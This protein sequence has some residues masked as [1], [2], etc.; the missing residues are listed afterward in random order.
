M[1]GVTM[2][3]NGNGEW[4]LPDTPE[5]L[6]A[7]G[8]PTPDYDAVSFAV[9]NLGFIKLQIFGQSII[10]IELHPRAVELPALLAAQQQV[11]SSQVKLFRIKYFDGEWASEITSAAEQVIARLS[12]LCAPRARPVGADRF[13]V[14][15]QDFGRLFR[16]EDN[17]LRPLAVK[18]R[19]SFGQFDSSVISLAVANGLL[20]RLVIVGITPGKG[21]PQWRFIGDGHKWIGSNYHL[22]GLGEQV[23]NMPDKDYGQWAQEYF[24]STAATR[25]PRYDL[26]SGSIQ[27]QD[28]A[29]RPSVP[30]RYERLL[31]PWKTA[32]AEVFVTSCS[33]GIDD[34]IEPSFSPASRMAEKVA[35][36]A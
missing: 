23:Q 1:Q 25:Q 35:N 18:W 15:P 12:E 14:E 19:M 28:A 6:E 13:V 22:R 8:D 29:G 2:L 4:L 11:L 24:K 16:E 17:W 3:V 32:S 27:Y 31:L 10:E 36:S 34:V 7:L 9:K 21:E 26:V 5:F 20:S 30:R 33:K